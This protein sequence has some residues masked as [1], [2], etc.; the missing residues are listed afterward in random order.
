MSLAPHVRP[1]IGPMASSSPPPDKE[2]SP[3]SDGHT[4]PTP[5]T[6][7]QL[8]ID[9]LYAQLRE[10]N[11]QLAHKTEKCDKLTRMQRH[12][13]DDIHELT[14][15]LFA[16]A[17]KMA[18]D[19]EGKRRAAEQRLAEATMAMDVMQAELSVLKQIVR[20]EQPLARRSSDKRSKTAHKLKNRFFP[21]SKK[22]RT[23][24]PPSPKV[25][26]RVYLVSSDLINSINQ[27]NLQLDQVARRELIEWQ[28]HHSLDCTPANVFIHRLYEE[29]I[30]PAFNF[31]NRTLAEQVLTAVEE[32][33][34]SIEE[35]LDDGFVDLTRLP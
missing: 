25:V 34:L 13:D 9:E 1:L 11:K 19:E 22:E 21:S 35:T 8:S 12:V 27:S 31:D 29:E 26:K 24:S 20:D 30:R 16:Q 33:R 6:S 7:T 23:A 15:H 32:N 4:P 18:G 17:Y 3:D 28:C 10:A 14:E 5:S 2:K